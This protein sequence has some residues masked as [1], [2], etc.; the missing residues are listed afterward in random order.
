MLSIYHCDGLADHLTLQL[1]YV[2]SASWLQQ[3][4]QLK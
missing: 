3:Q 2:P 1:L 4:T